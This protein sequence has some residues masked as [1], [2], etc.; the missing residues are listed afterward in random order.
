M[1]NL[2]NWIKAAPHSERMVGRYEGH[3]V[4]VDTCAV[5]DADDPYETA[6]QRGKKPCVIVE[7]YTTKDEAKAG[8]KRWK[9]LAKAGK[10]PP[11]LRHK[12]TSGLAKLLQAR[13]EDLDERQT[14]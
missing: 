9:E 10:L 1:D 4:I 8:H 7:A 11:R 13:G 6:I 12:G 14:H 5:N 3:G 2:F